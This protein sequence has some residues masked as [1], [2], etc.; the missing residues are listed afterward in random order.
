MIPD[1]Y[2]S[3]RKKNLLHT[4]TSDFAPVR[5]ILSNTWCYVVTHS[6]SSLIFNHS[7]QG[8]RLTLFPQRKGLRERINLSPK[9][10]RMWGFEAGLFVP[11]AKIP[12]SSLLCI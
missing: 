2:E 8:S 7:L 9:A 10:S 6:G 1:E 5:E 11:P 12:R 3:G 4:G